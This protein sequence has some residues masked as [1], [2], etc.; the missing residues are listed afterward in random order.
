MPDPPTLDHDSGVIL[1]SS[2]EPSA[3]KRKAYHS[4]VVHGK[5]L[6]ISKSADQTASAG[7]KFTLLFW[8]VPD[9]M[10][11]GLPKDDVLIVW[12]KVKDG[13]PNGT[14]G[15]S[16]DFKY[17]VTDSNG[18]Q[19]GERTVT[20]IYNDDPPPASAPPVKRA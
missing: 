1:A 6:G 20:V 5:G 9:P 7:T 10:N 15:T 2:T 19:S 18:L 14:L 11:M 4:F 12:V 16:E 3:D 13:E 17:K 8:T